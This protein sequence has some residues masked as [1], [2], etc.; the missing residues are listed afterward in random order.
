MKETVN[1]HAYQI[2]SLDNTNPS[3]SEILLTRKKCTTKKKNSA[4][5]STTDVPNREKAL[6]I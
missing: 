5:I 6:N 1:I 4:I 3:S 2:K